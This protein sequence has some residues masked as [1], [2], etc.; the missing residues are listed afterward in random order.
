MKIEPFK[1]VNRTRVVQFFRNIFQE[2]GWKEEKDDQ[3]DDPFGFFHLPNNGV[4]LLVKDN[5]HF[6][7]TAGFVK[8]NKK[9]AIVKRFYIENKFRGTGI[10]QTLLNALI[11]EARNLKLARLVLDVR[12][13]NKRAI[14][15]YEKC[16]FYGYIP[17]PISEWR[18]S[19][20]PDIF[21][22]FYIEIR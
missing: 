22:Y 1:V 6:I 4:L 8:L 21:E 3:V 5:H 2:M 20:S 14:R 13:T 15:F 7:G 10:A 17:K 18:E 19:Q 12:N 16:G 9:E 11:K